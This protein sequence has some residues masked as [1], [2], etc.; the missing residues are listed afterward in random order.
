MPLSVFIIREIQINKKNVNLLLIY[1]KASFILIIFLK[2]I[3][4]SKSMI[5]KR[6]FGLIKLYDKN[7]ENTLPKK[8]NLFLTVKN[9]EGEP[10]TKAMI[11]IS[12]KIDY[13][14]KVSVII[15]VYNIEEYLSQCLD[16]V[17][18]Q[19]LKEIEIICVDDGSTDNSLDIL[20]NY[21]KRD[22]RMTILKQ[23]NLHSGVARNAGISVAK[24]NYLSFLD[25]DDFFELDMLEKMYNKIFEK[26]SDI[27][28]CRCK[29]IDLNNGKFD[30]KKF[31]NSLNLALIPKKENFLH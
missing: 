23:E 9:A 29:S 18:N 20:I 10:D 19:T 3:F 15:P 4:F 1:I 5:N 2:Y 7:E 22:K 21:A 11:I 26:N 24:G 13:I 12:N 14:P 31:N 30:E 8:D 27:I 6:V 28:I 16:T 17:L 25:S